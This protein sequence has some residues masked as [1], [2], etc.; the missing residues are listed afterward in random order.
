MALFQLDPQSIADRARAARAPV[1][2][3]ALRDSLLRGMIG[4]TL[5]SVGG[6]APWP[7]IDRWF[8]RLGEVGLYVASAAVFIGG[9]GLLLH[10]LIIGPG[11]LARFYKVFA[12]RVH[13]LRGDLGRVLDGAARRSREH[14]RPARR[15][16]RD[17]RDAGLGVRRAARHRE[18]RRGAFRVEHAWLLRGR[19][20][21]R[22]AG[23][24]APA[25]GDAL[26]GSL[27]RPRLR[28]RAGT[29][30]SPLPK[31]GPGGTR[32]PSTPHEPTRENPV[33]DFGPGLA[34]SALRK[35]A[36]RRRGNTAM[37]NASRWRACRRCT[38]TC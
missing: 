3:P 16:R 36:H 35:P 20:D 28:R 38:R 32:A 11:S 34:V 8:P 26:L 33:P 9:S 1:A 21:R 24:R 15:H 27:L 17:G 19:L 6:F 29:R 25:G 10:R 22:E 18:N 13:R 14:C 2:V 30:V 37:S 5:V 31:P 23:H 4:F 12:P 7:I